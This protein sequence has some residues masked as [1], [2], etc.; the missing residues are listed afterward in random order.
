MADILER[1]DH[2]F[3]L[4][5]LEIESIFKNLEP[6]DAVYADLEQW[7]ATLPKSAPDGESPTRDIF[8]LDDDEFFR[9]HMSPNKTMAIPEPMVK[10]KRSQRGF[11]RLSDIVFYAALVLVLVLTFVSSKRENGGFRLLGYSGFTVL[12]DSM[13]REIPQGSLVL[14][15]EVDPDSIRVGDDITFVRSDNLLITHRVVSIHENENGIPGRAFETQGLENPLPDAEYT[16][17]S[18][19][20]GV[21]KS[22]IPELG[23]TWEYISKNIGIILIVLGALAVTAVATRKLF[24]EIKKD[25]SNRDVSPMEKGQKHEKENHQKIYHRRHR[26]FRLGDHHVGRNLRI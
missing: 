18:N 4:E 9:R 17:E 10:K 23:F 16:H 24:T 12:T 22:V 7:F 21:V 6:S 5:Y 19:V 25:T 13:Q 15:K 11:A 3:I 26:N 1:I 2:G 8:E 20:V 14:V